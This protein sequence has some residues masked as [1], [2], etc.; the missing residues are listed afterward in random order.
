MLRTVSRG[1]GPRRRARWS[2]GLAILVPVLWTATAASAGAH[3]PLGPRDLPLPEWA[4]PWI[5]AAV[6]LAIQVRWL[7]GRPAAPRSA[8]PTATDGTGRTPAAAVAL[9]VALGAL[10]VAGLAVALWA[11]STGTS[12]PRANLLPTVLLVGL[13]VG[14]P[15]ASIA[16]GDLWRW[17][18]PWGA[19]VDAAGWVG[20]RA[21]GPRGL[22][23][24]FRWPERLGSLPAAGVLLV[25][26]WIQVASP[27]RDDPAALALLGLVY[28]AV[29]LAGAGAFGRAFLDRVDGFALLGRMGAALSPWTVRDG[30]PALRRPGAGLASA[31]GD[32]GVPAGAIALAATATFDG[33]ASTGAWSGDD[34]IG[35]RLETLFVDLGLPD[36]T[37]STVGSTVGLL[38]VAGALAAVAAGVVVALRRAGG[39]R[40]G[41]PAAR[42]AGGLVAAGLA[43]IVA[44]YGSLL[45]SEAPTI[46][47]LVSDPR[48]DGSD[49]FGTASHTGSVGQSGAV[50]VWLVQLAVVAALHVALLVTLRPAARGGRRATVRVATVGLVASVAS[51]AL[52]LWLST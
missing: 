9:R 22:P 33:V 31:A 17:L 20:R 23:E 25:V 42:V 3:D 51:V 40:D 8:A 41:D 28:T 34:G 27:A 5:V 44:H 38:L 4:F 39:A 48:G 35:P 21:S 15:V 29:L 18:S 7:R 50:A 47:S 52:A 46:R 12:N 24:P 10:G 45:V 49:W 1:R 19:V 36:G 2:L 11:G 26:G 14:L 13:L 16:V 32:P 6:L 37:A 43:T 30:R